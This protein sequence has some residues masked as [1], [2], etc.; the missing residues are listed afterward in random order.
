MRI[1]KIIKT[2]KNKMMNYKQIM[3]IMKMKQMI[4]I[5]QKL[6]HLIIN[7]NSNNNNNRIKI[8]IQQVNQNKKNKIEEID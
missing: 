5:Q 1:M 7:N 8:S 3:K 6:M 4:L 2:N